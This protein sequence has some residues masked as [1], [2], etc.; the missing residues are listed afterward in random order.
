MLYCF[1]MYGSVCFFLFWSVPCLY[2]EWIDHLGKQ[3][4][5]TL[6]APWNESEIWYNRVM[7]ELPIFWKLRGRKE[8]MKLHS[9]QF[10]LKGHVNSHT[11]K[12]NRLINDRAR[13]WTYLLPELVFRP[14]L[15]AALSSTV[16]GVSALVTV[17]LIWG[18]RLRPRIA[19]LVM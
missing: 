12:I 19:R 11:K 1:V 2:R 13:V 10:L 4:E 15:Q 18:A 5:K 9:F 3:R 17:H 7:L 8:A 16:G 14:A 6:P